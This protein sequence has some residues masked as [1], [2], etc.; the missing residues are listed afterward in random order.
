MLMSW[1]MIISW[2]YKMY[3]FGVWIFFIFENCLLVY[4]FIQFTG[5]NNGVYYR[6]VHNTSLFMVF[7]GRSVNQLHF[8]GQSNGQQ[9]V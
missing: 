3:L 4:D 8:T 9:H 1:L 6:P 5:Q 7:I 2:V